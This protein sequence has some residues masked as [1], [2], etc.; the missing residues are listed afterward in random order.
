MEIWPKKTDGLEAIF[1]EAKRE[2]KLPEDNNVV[3]R[4]VSREL[5]KIGIV[6]SAEGLDIRDQPSSAR[7][8]LVGSHSGRCD[9]VV[10]PAL[11][12]CGWFLVCMLID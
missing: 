3:L 7:S 10:D 5:W 2:L 9:Q 12:L 8:L 6:Q 1:V 4:F 11:L